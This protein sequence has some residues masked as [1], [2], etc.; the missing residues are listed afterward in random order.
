V[1][2]VASNKKVRRRKKRALDPIARRNRRFVTD[3]RTAFTNCGFVQISTREIEF[4]HGGFT[5][6]FDAI[7]CKNNVLV[8]VEDTTDRDPGDHLR[9]KAEAW[10]GMAADSEAFVDALAAKF[11]S[12]AEHLSKHTEFASHDYQVRFVYISLKSLAEH[13]IARYPQIGFLDNPRLQYFVSLS[14][15]VSRS[16]L[17]ELL[18]FLKIDLATFGVQS[19]ARS[20]T[21]Y[22]GLYLPETP[23]GFSKGHKIVSLLMDPKTLLERSYVLRAD[24]WKDTD[25]LYQRLLVKNKIKE[26]RQ[27][28][29][30]EG[31][32]F[33][34]NV[35][36]TFPSD[37]KLLAG[38]KPITSDDPA[39]RS[40]VTPVDITLPHRLA[41]IGIIDGQHR[42][43]A[44]HEGT[45]DLESHIAKLRV[46]QHLLV[47]GIIYPTSVPTQAAQ[48]FEAKLFLEINDKQKRVRG[49][50]K[51][52]IEMIV[53]PRSAVAIAK[54]VVNALAANQPFLDI[55]ET[56]AF[57]TGKL[58]TTSIVSY[59][60][61]YVVDP[62]RE[63]SMFS[64]WNSE[65]KSSFSSDSAALQAYISYCVSAL[66][67][68]FNAFKETVGDDMWTTERDKSR[69]LNA[70]S[71]NGLIYA[72]R[73]IVA[74]GSPP[75]FD[76]AKKRFKKLTVSFIPTRFRYKSSHWKE[77][78]ERIFDEC[79][80]SG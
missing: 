50:L 63:D 55:L 58:K 53:R 33:V 76:D 25:A 57:D 62:D 8:V 32:V 29:K 48:Q 14:K 23:S 3:I 52:A 19:S 37:T 15:T 44:Y 78:G 36:V 80:K 34:N 73:R 21:T 2:L 71:I 74:E 66:R 59:G 11:P 72:M 5:S 7:F 27:Y 9:K 12:V 61:K 1:A 77:L 56:H 31:R 69:A 46:K 39:R 41:S 42:I 10:E 51:Q 47:T 24:G 6:D 17:F 4:T 70:T 68:Y 22:S 40:G 75:T 18:N 16:T 54:A 67:R 13:L 60:L 38:G 43:F 26:M 79:F 65:L 28:L 64:R 49:D 35:I 45:D 30:Q 20:D